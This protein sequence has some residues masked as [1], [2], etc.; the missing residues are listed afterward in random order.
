MSLSY[1][2]IQYFF[3]VQIEKEVS[4]LITVS[5]IKVCSPDGKVIKIIILTTL[6]EQNIF[7]FSNIIFI[8]VYL[9]IPRSNV[10]AR[11]IGTLL[12]F[13]TIDYHHSATNQRQIYKL[14]RRVWEI[15]Q[16]DKI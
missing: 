10:R 4:L 1:R 6:Q 8:V 11:F 5:G 12:G 9:V 3:Q 15:V 14:N 7:N 13:R 16:T 2:I